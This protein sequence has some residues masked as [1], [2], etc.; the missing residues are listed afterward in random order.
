M[1]EHRREPRNNHARSIRVVSLGTLIPMMM[2]AA[3]LV[4]AAL[5]WGAQKLW[6]SIS[7]W[8]I[9][10][11]VAVGFA[12]GVRETIILIKRIDREQSRKD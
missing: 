5:G 1:P 4:G 7:P 9:V 6:P 3:P 11:G 2:V 8:G 12:S 10:A